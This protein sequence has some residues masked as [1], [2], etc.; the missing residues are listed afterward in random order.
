[1]THKTPT[2]T[3]G[4]L[5]GLSVGAAAG[6]LLAPRKGEETRLQLQQKAT[7]A[8]DKIKH[9]LTRQRNK[10]K[11]RLDEVV[12]KAAETSDDMMRSM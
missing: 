2:M 6:M 5:L 1:M 10:A 4:F 7:Q 11:Q 8:R 12:D 9:Q 3:M